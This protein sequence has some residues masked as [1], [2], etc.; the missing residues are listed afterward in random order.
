V[1]R[2]DNGGGGEKTLGRRA[3]GGGETETT[4]ALSQVSDREAGRV[5]CR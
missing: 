5:G 4:L 2:R 1:E 3:G